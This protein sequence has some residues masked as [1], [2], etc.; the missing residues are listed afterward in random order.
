MQLS[1][2]GGFEIMWDNEAVHIYVIWRE[3]GRSRFGRSIKNFVMAIT[4]NYSNVV[5]FGD[6]GFNSSLL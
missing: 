1:F 3:F 5:N 6:P 2:L 4:S